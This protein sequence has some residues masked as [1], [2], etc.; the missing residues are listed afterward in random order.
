MLFQFIGLV[1][2]SMPIMDLLILYYWWLSFKYIYICV[3]VF[4]GKYIS[5]KFNCELTNI[6]LFFA[7]ISSLFSAHLSRQA[8]KVSL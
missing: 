2:Y 3:C 5:N 6:F 1:H 4:S 8:H 7:I